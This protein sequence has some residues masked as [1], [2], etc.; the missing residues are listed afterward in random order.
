M[1]SN[2]PRRNEWIKYN[3]YSEMQSV[4]AMAMAKLNDKNELSVKLLF[5]APHG[6][7]YSYLEDANIEAE[8]IFGKYYKLQNIH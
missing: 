3:I 6:L 8:R 1:K 4:V 5:K 2:R 7:Y